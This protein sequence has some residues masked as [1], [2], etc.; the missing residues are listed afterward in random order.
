MKTGSHNPKHDYLYGST[1]VVQDGYAYVVY[2]VVRCVGIARVDAVSL[3]ETERLALVKVF[4]GVLRHVRRTAQDQKTNQKYIFIA[5]FQRKLKE[6]CLAPNTQ[7]EAADIATS[8]HLVAW[9]EY[10]L[11]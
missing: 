10:V 6:G 2:P 8:P 11:R 3:G 4:S 9:G 5:V 1:N 7:E